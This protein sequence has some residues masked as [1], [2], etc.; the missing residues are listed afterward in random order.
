[1]PN[2]TSGTVGKIP[3]PYVSDVKVDEG[4][5]EYVPFPTTSIGSRRSGL[6]SSASEGPK[7][8]EHVGTS[9]GMKGKHK[10]PAENS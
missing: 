3:G 10:G 9:E 2:P 8:L 4:I 1:M 7:S 6:P 5:M